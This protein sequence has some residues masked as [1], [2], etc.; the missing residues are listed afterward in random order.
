MR[1]KEGVRG[2]RGKGEERERDICERGEEDKPQ[3]LLLQHGR[4]SLGMKLTI[5]E[6]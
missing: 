3:S 6:R 1:E 5:R 2:K 4:R